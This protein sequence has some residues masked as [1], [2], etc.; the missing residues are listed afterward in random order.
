[1]RKTDHP[2]R[3][4]GARQAARIPSAKRCACRLGASPW[5]VIM[6]IGPCVAGRRWMSTRRRA[7]SGASR[8]TQQGTAVSLALVAARARPSWV[9][10]DSTKSPGMRLHWLRKSSSSLL[11]R[12]APRLGLATP[13][14]GRPDRASRSRRPG[15]GALCGAAL[16]C[17]SRL[18][19]RKPIAGAHGYPVQPPVAPRAVSAAHDQHHGQ[20]QDRVNRPRAVNVQ[21][22]ANSPAPSLQTPRLAYFGPLATQSRAFSGPVLGR[23]VAF[24]TPNVYATAAAA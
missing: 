2:A 9:E 24:E 8:N 23:A 17:L 1:M 22:P 12:A 11:R 4:A 20:P 7:G 13:R 6:P 10:A 19:C 5:C 21:R 14:G 18:R 15:S 16:R 3:C